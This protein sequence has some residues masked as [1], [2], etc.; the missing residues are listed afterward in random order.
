MMKY[1]LFYGLFCFVMASSCLGYTIA[2]CNDGKQPPGYVCCLMPM[3]GD[4]WVGNNTQRGP[5]PAWVC[6]DMSS[7]VSG[8][9][10]KDTKTA[11]EERELSIMRSGKCGLR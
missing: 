7:P 1:Q 10:V 8:N 4:R 6:K 3:K 9:C 2:T 5:E 11:L